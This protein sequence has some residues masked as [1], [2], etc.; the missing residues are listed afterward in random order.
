MFFVFWFPA[1]VQHL[2]EKTFNT[3][4][5]STGLTPTP[6]DGTGRDGPG[7]PPQGTVALKSTTVIIAARRVSLIVLLEVASVG[8]VWVLSLVTR[9]PVGLVLTAAM[10]LVAGLVSAQTRVV[11]FVTGTVGIT[12]TVVLPLVALVWLPGEG[13]ATPVVVGR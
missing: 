10:A 11:A 7:K 2:F 8:L 13:L 5:Q 3:D 12:V 6:A 1:F 4:T 9:T